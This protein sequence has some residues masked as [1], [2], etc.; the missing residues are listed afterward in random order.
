VS[1]AGLPDPR[2][3]LYRSDL[4]AD[5]LRG[6][7]EAP[8]YVAGEGFQITAP[9]LPLRR[10]PRPDAPLETEGLFGETLMLYDS[11]EGWGW[12]QLSRD[13]Y[14]GY[15]P[16]EG[17]SAGIVAPTHQITAL[18]TYIYPAPDIK[19]PPLA[20]L[21][22]NARVSA[23][24]EADEFL[25]LS[26]GGFVFAEHAATL[27]VFAGDFV[28]VAEAFLGTP[29]LWGGRTSLGVDCS[30]LVQLAL[31]AA[32]F[33]VPR[34]TDMQAET[35]GEPIPRFGPY[36]RGDLVFWRGHVG[37]M[38]SPQV[39]L[40]ANAFHMQVAREPLSQAETRIAHAGEQ[41]SVVKRLPALS[42]G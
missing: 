13:G 14:V 30:G 16:V 42:A 40:H 3:N 17:L 32:G 1:E 26:G 39:L 18:R 37:I 38:T 34:D 19:L 25:S 41:V 4:A 7:V 8:R 29:Y 28:A 10:S 35:I 12:V 33:E 9:H 15:A 27:N 31:E 20:Q 21:S 22:L 23:K 36:R 5:Y 24:G 11:R 2:L 6:R